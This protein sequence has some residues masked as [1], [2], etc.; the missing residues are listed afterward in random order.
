[1]RDDTNITQQVMVLMPDTGALLRF[2]QNTNF[3]D[4]DDA[5]GV[6]SHHG[7]YAELAALYRRSGRWDLMTWVMHRYL[8]C[9]TVYL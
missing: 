3:I 2:V 9:T 7:M 6:L 5:I 1:M 4:L 8:P